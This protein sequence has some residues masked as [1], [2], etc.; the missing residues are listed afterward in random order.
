M[1]ARVLDHTS[2]ERP[3]LDLR[4]IGKTFRIRR[5]EQVTALSAVDLSIEPGEFIALI[6]P[7]GCGK[8]TLLRIISGLEAPSEGTVSVGGEA[9]ARLIKEHR[10]GIAFQEHALLPWATVTEN[11]A[12]PFRL[13]RLSVDEARVAELIDLVG[14]NGF[15]NARPKQLSGGMRQRVAIARSLALRPDLLLL[16]EPFGALDEITRRRMNLEL[17][18]IWAETGV[19]TVMVTHSV[20]E[21]LLLADRVVVMGTRPGR[22]VK[23]VVVDIERPRG[24]ETMATPRFAELSARLVRLLDQ[25]DQDPAR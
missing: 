21:A 2:L 23:E 1:S 24:I 6:G 17:A 15:E 13:A 3:T 12:L 5:G 10:V 8:S 18:R 7:S 14:L 16:D 9:P 4:G 19:T 22:I 11:V 25:D 20:D